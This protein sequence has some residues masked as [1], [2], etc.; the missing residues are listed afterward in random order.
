MKDGAIEKA[1]VKFLDNEADLDDLELLENSLQDEEKIS[2]FNDLVKVDYLINYNMADYNV[3]TAINKISQRVKYLQ[4][5]KRLLVFKRLSVA[6]SILLIIGVF[7]FDF[8]QFNNESSVNE[9]DTEISIGSSKAT[10]TLDN[11]NK[12]VLQK[13]QK[14]KTGEVIDQGEDVFYVRQNDTKSRTRKKQ[15]YNYLTIPRGGKFIIVLADG[16][17]VWLNSD[18]QLKYPTSFIEG[19]PR[20]VELVYGEAYF[21]VSPSEANH[22][23]SFSVYTKSQE[24]NVLGTEFNILAYNEDDVIKTTLVG[25]KVLIKKGSAERILKPNQQASVVLDSNDISI[26]E[27]DVSNE[28]SWV[29]GLFSFNGE[30]LEEMMKVLSRWY[31]TEIIFNNMEAK[32]FRFTGVLERTKSIKEILN[33]IEQTSDGEIQFD[34]KNKTITIK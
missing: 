1:I 9:N 26:K 10:L 8:F 34:V 28:I 33:Y 30:R 24:I 6:A 29:K 22:G 13:G 7:Y 19:K 4:R 3:E 15:V 27:V 2:I 23:D 11:G 17:K 14:Y 25:G 16:T 5:K 21:E 18:S 32:D 20:S 12:I 31:D